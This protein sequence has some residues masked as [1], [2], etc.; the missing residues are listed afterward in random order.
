[1]SASASYCDLVSLSAGGMR[2]TMRQPGAVIGNALR[3]LVG[4]VLRYGCDRAELGI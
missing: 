2:V 1:M 3:S 4:A